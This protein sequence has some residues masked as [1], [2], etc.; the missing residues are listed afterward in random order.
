MHMLRSPVSLWQ[1][2][3]MTASGS[4][5]PL[6]QQRSAQDSSGQQAPGQEASG[7]QPLEW[8]A[9][10]H[11]LSAEE[12]ERRERGNRFCAV[13][14]FWLGLILSLWLLFPFF[15]QSASIEFGFFLFMVNIYMSPF[16]LALL[17]LL[18]YLGLRGYAS[19]RRP[20][21]WIGMFTGFGTVGAMILYFLGS[22]IGSGS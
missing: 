2:S 19:S 17:L 11:D 6:Q 13:L 22:M 4:K 9:P 8:R 12:K 20:I 1:N 18:L 21:A 3:I 7:Q 16:Y 14:A 5:Q 10:G 15:V